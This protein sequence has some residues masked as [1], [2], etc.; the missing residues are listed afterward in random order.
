MKKRIIALSVAA[1]L[2]GFAGSASAQSQANTLQFNPRGVGHILLAPYF[3][4]QSSNVTLLNI[5]NTDRVFGKV[6]KIRFRGASNSDDLFDFQLFMSPGDMWSAEIAAGSDGVSTLTTFDKS[7]TLPTSVKSGTP[8]KFILSRTSPQATDRNMETREGYIE[9]LNMGDIAD[10]GGNYSDLYD[11]T[12]HVAGVP[13]CTPSVLT[14]IT[15]ENASSYMT[16]PTTGLMAGWTIINVNKVLAYS[17]DTAAIEARDIADGSPGYGRVVFWDQRSIGLSQTEADNNTADPLLRGAT[18][19][20]AGARYDLPD[21][22]TPYT[23]NL[24]VPSPLSPYAQSRELSNSIATVEAAGEFFNL[25]AVGASTDWVVSFPT[26]RYMAAVKYGT[27]PA[28]VRT[29]FSDGNVY[30]TSGNTELGSA[31]NGGKSYQ[32]CAKLGINAVGFFNREEVPTITDDI[33]ISPG[34]PT[35]LSLC[36]EVSVVGVNG[37]TPGNSATFAEVARSNISNG[38]TEGWGF[39]Y[40]PNTQTVGLVTDDFGL[41]FLARQFTRI[42]NTTT[43]Q[44]Y[45]LSYPM[46]IT[47]TG[48]SVP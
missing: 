6:L 13:D 22:S 39:L 11:A 31:S 23:W 4:T 25:A 20:V 44:F 17:G 9:I 41:P 27:T 12:K 26:R 36:G 28:I 3:S 7:C 8:Q 42:S 32:I 19:V 2:G 10:Y 43:N 34:T 16:T 38:F 37:T 1:A 21:L 46:R 35:I 45:G 18:P 29:A 48:A 24:T 33:V 40:A 30:F 15:N 14:A 5:T 47:Q